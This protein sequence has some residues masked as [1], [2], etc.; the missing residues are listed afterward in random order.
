M[1][2][3]TNEK[4]SPL[5]IA[6][7][8]KGLMLL[9]SFRGE[10][11]SLS[12]VDMAE[13][14][15]MNKST[16]QRL[17]FT[18]EALGYFAKDPQT[19][20]YRLTPKSL[21]I[22]TGYL[23]TSELVERANPYLHELNGTTGESC[24]LLE[25]CETDM[26]YVS[27]FA[28]HKQISVPIALG[29]RL[30]MYCSSAGRAFL[31]ALSPAAS[32]AILAQSKLQAFTHKTEIDPQALRAVIQEARAAGY[33]TS[34]EQYYIGDIAVAAP[35]VN[36]QGDPLAAL[37]VA[38]PF[39]RWTLDSVIEQLAPQVVNTARAISNAARSLHPLTDHH[40]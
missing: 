5:F 36:A 39:S 37:N 6:S 25:P 4:E 10:Y 28:G 1:T 31:A 29:Q 20:R 9:S 7:F 30:P 17:A 13:I 27:R 33:A 16:V 32:D 19:R 38:V 3:A 15:G 14:T 26:I 22:G 18:L 23:Q 35:I 2:A 40:R 8:A 34:N 24:N 11:S 21:E 12:L